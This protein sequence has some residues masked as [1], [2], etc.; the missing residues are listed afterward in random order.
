[1][2]KNTKEFKTV[3]CSCGNEIEVKV[4]SIDYIKDLIDY[5]K[6]AHNA[7]KNLIDDNKV[8]PA[9]KIYYPNSNNYETLGNIRA[10]APH[11]YSN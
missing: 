5:S 6:R 9:T 1:M 10:E 4:Y 11:K 2:L 8:S 7:I 3:V